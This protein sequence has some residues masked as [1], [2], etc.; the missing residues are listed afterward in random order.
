MLVKGPLVARTSEMIPI[1]SHEFQLGLGATDCFIMLTKQ[2]AHTFW[3]FSV[4]DWT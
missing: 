2:D 3:S 1:L 4:S